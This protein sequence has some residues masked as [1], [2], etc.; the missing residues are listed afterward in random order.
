MQRD[1]NALADLIKPSNLNVCLLLTYQ[2]AKNAAKEKHLSCEHIGQAKNIVDVMSVNLMMRRVGADEKNLNYLR[3]Q[4]D[5]EAEII[6]SDTE[7]LLIFVDKN[8][9]GPVL[10][11]PLLYEV[12]YSRQVIKEKGYAIL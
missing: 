5:N 3:Y 9:N 2:L 6:N 4:G 12:D 10:Q 1:A 8:R 11:E 7:Y